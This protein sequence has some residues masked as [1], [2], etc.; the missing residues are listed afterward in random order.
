M[1][2]VLFVCL[3][4]ICRS[5][6]AD[7]LMRQLVKE[8]GLENKILID[9]AGTSGMHSGKGPDARTQAVAK[10][11]GCD[12]SQ[13]KARQ[14]VAED[15]NEFDYILAMDNSNLTNIL[16]LA[17]NEALK[18]KAQLFL[19]FGNSD[20]T[21]VPDPYHGGEE[22]F[23]QVYDL[24]LATCKQLLAHLQEEHAL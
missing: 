24:I 15:F 21:Q 13:L 14:F 4:N 22:G 5:P 12:L 11:K 16:K 2:K 8:A 6:T 18:D 17:P 7:G 20:L 9:S 3:G 10:E 1:I 23:Y 19:N